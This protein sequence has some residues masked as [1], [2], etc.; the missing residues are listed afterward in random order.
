MC[1]AYMYRV[2]RST[3]NIALYRGSGRV[4]LGSSG[5]IS[6]SVRGL[7]SGGDGFRGDLGS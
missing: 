1:T 2:L 5:S 4:R 7:G 3:A 6:G